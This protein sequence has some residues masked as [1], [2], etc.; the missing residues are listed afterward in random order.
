MYRHVEVVEMVGTITGRI[1]ICQ[2]GLQIQKIHRLGRG[3]VTLGGV[4]VAPA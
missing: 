2:V 1:R 4:D 3:D